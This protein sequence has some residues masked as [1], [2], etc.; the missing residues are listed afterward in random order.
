MLPIQKIATRNR[1]RNIIY[2]SSTEEL[3]ASSGYPVYNCLAEEELMNL[4]EGEGKG[5]DIKVCFHI[6]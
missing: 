1:N 2:S 6:V 5:I 4:G 3:L